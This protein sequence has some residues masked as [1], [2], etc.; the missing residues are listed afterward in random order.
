M[1]AAIASSA[2][3]VSS[4]TARRTPA[5]SPSRKE[6]DCVGDAVSDDDC[7]SASSRGN[8][9][10][11]A[12]VYRVLSLLSTRI[13]RRPA[14]EVADGDVELRRVLGV[15][16]REIGRDDS[17]PGR[18]IGSSWLLCD[19]SAP[20]GDGEER[21]EVRMRTERSCALASSH[22]K[23]ECSTSRIRAASAQGWGGRWFPDACF[24]LTCRI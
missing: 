8:P 13:R 16:W 22:R 9:D 11:D 12:R 19:G 7:W 21:I 15:L 24:P 1:N 3:A 17:F 10:A 18:L 23:R 20:S 6:S 4:S 14:V 2:V 5:R